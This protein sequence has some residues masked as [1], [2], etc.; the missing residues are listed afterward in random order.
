[1]KT[2][3][4]I[5]LGLAAG[6][7]ALGG[8]AGAA[9]LARADDPTATPTAGATATPGAGQRGQHGGQ[10]GSHDAAALATKLGLEESVVSDAMDAVRTAQRSAD[11]TGTAAEREAAHVKALAAEL[12]VDE[13]TLT[14]ALAEI[15][16]EAG[17]KRDQA[18][19][20]RLDEAV[21]DGTLT[22][23]EAD[24]VRKAADA[25][26]ISKGGGRR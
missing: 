26:V 3:H 25:G 1:M 10:R 2:T 4:K 9:T 22:Q 5:G 20:S 11:K 16:A 12:K 21:S 24:A 6:A 7:L 15:R 8:A 17:Q 18:F 13:A 23:A 14:K 19:S